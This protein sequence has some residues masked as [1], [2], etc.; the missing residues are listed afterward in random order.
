[1]NN[2]TGKVAQIQGAVVDCEFPEEILP[3]IYEA[4]ELH[5]ENEDP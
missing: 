5:R 1:M 2:S 4:I 3:E